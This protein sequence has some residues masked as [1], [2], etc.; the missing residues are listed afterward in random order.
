MSFQYP[1]GSLPSSMNPQPN[2][3]P[4][5]LVARETADIRTNINE[6]QAAREHRRVVVSVL[7]AFWSDMG[8][9]C[10]SAVAQS[11]EGHGL[12]RVY[13]DAARVNRE[14]IEAERL[15]DQIRAERRIAA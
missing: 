5:A 13:G 14:R 3:Y 1:G 7:N 10:A 6:R 8:I 2:L 12:H 4:A 15:A 9:T 11:C